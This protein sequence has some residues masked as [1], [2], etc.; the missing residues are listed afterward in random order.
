M[1]RGGEVGGG[2]GEGG[3]G[4]GRKWGVEKGKGGGGRGGKWPGGECSEGSE[5]SARAVVPHHELP[6]GRTCYDDIRIW[7]LTQLGHMHSS[8]QVAVTKQSDSAEAV[9]GDETGASGCIT[10]VMRP[11]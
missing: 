5:G 10:T 7:R 8:L 6:L 1:K 3:G 9:C 2:G 4:W 11:V